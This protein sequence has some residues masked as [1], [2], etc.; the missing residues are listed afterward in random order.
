L[1]EPHST[2]STLSRR[3]TFAIAVGTALIVGVVLPGPLTASLAPRIRDDFA[4]SDATV[5]LAVALYYVLSA[6]ISVPLGGIVERIGAAAAMRLAAA[7]MIATSLAIAA[8]ADS[9]T[10]LVALLLAGSGG[11]AL[12]GPAVSAMLRREVQSRR[13]GLAFGAQQSG[14]SLAGLA[15]GLALPAIAIP[16]GWRWAFVVSALL[17]LPALAFAPRDRDEPRHE[18]EHHP[19]DRRAIYLLAGVAALASGAVF[20]LVSFLV[21]YSVHSG[22]AEGTAGFL[23]A[24]VGMLATGGRLAIGA[25]SDRPGRDPLSPVATLLIL[26]L[27]GYALLVTGEPVLIACGALIA[28]GLGWSWAGALTHAVVNRSQQAPAWGVS[29]M[30]AGLLGGN[31]V[32]P[33]AIGLFAERDAYAAAWTLCA[34]LTAIAAATVI[35]M[36]RRGR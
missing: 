15:A 33:L 17:A 9:A 11:H 6:A 32:G 35:A 7:M 21:I 23:L 30:L 10:A 3:G 19:G 14:A 5:G 26:S 34:V 31:S 24:A 8:F 1:A 22:I 13:H 28:G 27:P 29:V 4:F 25:L 16:F 12:A 20:G 36:R 18:R 2:D